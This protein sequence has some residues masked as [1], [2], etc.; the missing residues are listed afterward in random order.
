[1]VGV[2]FLGAAGLFRFATEEH[3]CFTLISISSTSSREFFFQLHRVLYDNHKQQHLAA[4]RTFRE[5][6]RDRLFLPDPEGAKIINIRTQSFQSR[7]TQES[8]QLVA[9]LLSWKSF[10]SFRLAVFVD[11]Y[12]DT[13]SRDKATEGGSSDEEEAFESA[14]EG[15]ESSKTAK[16]TSATSADIRSANSTLKEL[17]GKNDASPTS[18]VASGQEMNTETAAERKQNTEMD[19]DTIEIEKEH[20][21]EN[22]VVEK[23]P[24]IK[25]EHSPSPE[26]VQTIESRSE[27][28]EDTDQLNIKT[29]V[30]EDETKTKRIEG[31]IGKTETDHR[32]VSVG[33]EQSPE[34]EDELVA[35]KN[36]EER[37]D[38]G[39]NEMSGN[40]AN[41]QHNDISESFSDVKVEDKLDR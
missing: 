27:P 10:R 15:E 12:M 39:Q 17:V 5:L 31:G 23:D 30:S 41:D 8:H 20:E 21:V 6:P 35:G 24:S 2:V 14:D 7:T 36:M 26:S 37:N 13:I 29:K 32:G 4:T 16:P 22:L 38:N 40:V 18:Q 3:P 34:N 1:M 11:L 9:T 19:N 33:H 28:E 25:S